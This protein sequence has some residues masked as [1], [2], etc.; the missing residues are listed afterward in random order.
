[1]E[2]KGMTSLKTPNPFFDIFVACKF[3]PKNK[4]DILVNKGSN[5]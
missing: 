2:D 5:F 4:R 3:S 1:M